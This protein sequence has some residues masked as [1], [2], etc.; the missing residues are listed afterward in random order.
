VSTEECPEVS[1]SNS[2]GER[3]R[4]D[5]ALAAQAHVRDGLAE[6]Q[7]HLSDQLAR[8]DHCANILVL[9]K[10]DFDDSPVSQS[11]GRNALPQ[12]FSRPR[13]RKWYALERTVLIA[14]YELAERLA[15]MVPVS[16][17][18]GLRQDMMLRVRNWHHHHVGLLPTHRPV[19][20]RIHA[21]VTCPSSDTVQRTLKTNLPC[22]KKFLVQ[23][24][25]QSLITRLA[26][27]I[28]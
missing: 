22:S 23:F 11:P 16:I 14:H 8:R 24:L 15:A 20:K 10:V 5:L 25:A 17:S 28:Q 9:F 27:S 21:S 12:V 1:A 6:I 3:N 2:T 18:V 7:K 13:T 19:V 4:P 26:E